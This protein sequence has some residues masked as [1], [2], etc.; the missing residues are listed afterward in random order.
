MLGGATGGARGA[1]GIRSAQTRGQ[2]TGWLAACYLG[3]GALLFGGAGGGA[4][5][6]TISVDDLESCPGGLAS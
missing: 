5:V 2:S 6:Y 1:R 4:T 3:A